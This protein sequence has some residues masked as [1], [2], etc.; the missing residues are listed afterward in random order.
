MIRTLAE[1][2]PAS[3]ASN[4]TRQAEGNPSR[5][6]TTQDD[7]ICG[8]FHDFP[9]EWSVSEFRP[10][11]PISVNIL[12]IEYS[13]GRLRSLCWL[14]GGHLTGNH[15][16]ALPSQ[17]LEAIRQW[18]TARLAGAFPD[19]IK[20]ALRDNSREFHLEPAGPGR[21]DLI[22]VLKLEPRTLGPAIRIQSK[23]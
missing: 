22:P 15:D 19:H 20:E 12:A 8:N 11:S 6:I 2:A 21:W 3:R 9:L 23:G 4:A 14:L 10:Y 18:E 5:L 16:H 17:I 13:H 1:A 7:R